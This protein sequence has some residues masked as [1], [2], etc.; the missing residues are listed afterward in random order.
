M[1]DGGA[2]NVALPIGAN[3]GDSMD[4]DGTRMAFQHGRNIAMWVW[5]GSVDA[6]GAR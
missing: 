1:N 6:E 5:D 3:W 4:W 2:T